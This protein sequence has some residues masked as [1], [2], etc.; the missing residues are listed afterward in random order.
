VVPDSQDDNG[1]PINEMTVLHCKGG[2]FVGG[3]GKSFRL[4]VML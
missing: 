1:A 4:A 3:W 2:H